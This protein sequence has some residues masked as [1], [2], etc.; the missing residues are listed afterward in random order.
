MYVK[1]F[2]WPCAFAKN[3]YWFNQLIDFC[4]DFSVYYKY[5]LFDRPHCGRQL[6]YWVNGVNFHENRSRRRPS[7]HLVDWFLV[8]AGWQNCAMNLHQD[9]HLIAASIRCEASDSICQ[10]NWL[11][12]LC[13]GL[14]WFAVSCAEFLSESNLIYSACSWWRAKI[15]A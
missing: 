5:L 10:S 12:L 2:A 4:A 3:F 11:Q 8:S 6:L 14:L 13:S 9:T 15:A 1:A 7:L